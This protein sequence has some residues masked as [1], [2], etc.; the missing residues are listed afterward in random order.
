MADSDVITAGD[1][2]LGIEFG[3]T[4]IKAVLTGPD[5]AVLA[6]GVHDWE[7]VFLP[8]RYWSYS[9]DAVWSGLQDCYARLAADVQARHGVTLSTVGAIGV[10]AMM[11]GYLA[12]DAAGELLAPF[13]TWRNTTTGP[14]AA[15]LTRLFGCNI[16]QRW[17]IAHLYQAI[18][19]D[20]AHVGRI[21]Y[22]TT[23]AG[24]VHWQLTGE[25][26][27]GVGDA[28][29]M[30]PIDPATGSYDVTR[31]A[32][33]DDLVA[34]RGYGWALADLLPR[35]LP[36]GAAAGA[37]SAEGAKLL[38]PSGTLGQAPAPIPLCPPEGDAGTGMVATNSVARRT[39]NVSA[40]TSLFAMVV[41][42]R[43]LPLHE[44]IDIVTTPAG[45]PVAMV[46]CN[47]GASELDAWAGLF[48]EFA[49]RAGV[50][51]ADAV[52]FGA[53]FRAALDGEPDAGGVLAFNYLAGEPITGLAEGRP[54]VVRPPDA[55]FTLANFM[56]AQLFAAFAT[57][58]LG[59][60]LLEAEGVAVDRLFAHG[61]VF[62][63]EGVAQRLLAAALGAPVTVGDTAAEGGAWGMAVLADYRR[64]GGGTPL[65]DWLDTAVFAG[66]ATRTLAPDP[67]DVAG[68]AAFLERYERALA[69][70]RAAV[71][72]I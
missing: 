36:A 11:H 16:P 4:R 53:L 8:E 40:G 72:A 66:A 23:L 58:K 5:H 71:A 14:A 17:S 63:T 41:L 42:E 65:A 59:M 7:N 6:L 28:S 26:V 1:T 54:L 45:D 15:E 33:F 9:L 13:R 21:A 57:L 35:V 30:F 19:N 50:P 62:K 2:A 46:H 34:P 52:T 18:L 24:Y 47:N 44:E 31:L 68:F 67:A 55:R 37:L 38:D 27:L 12:F 39:G 3:S 48:G 60:R 20:E 32:Q 51:V 61:G 10:S 69:V 22:L 49:A 43:E 25:K 29:G 64:S 56:R 70:Q